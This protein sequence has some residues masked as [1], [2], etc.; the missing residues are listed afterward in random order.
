M[1]QPNRKVEVELS[2]EQREELESLC[3]RTSAPVSQVRNARVLLLADEDRRLG[4][5]PDWYIREQTGVSLRQICRIRQRFAEEGLHPAV[6]RK[7]RAAPPTP[8]RFD[9]RQE[10]HLVQLC[11]SSPPEGRKRWTLRL[12][13]DELCRLQVVA[14]VSPE[15]VRQCLKKIACSPGG[16]SGSASLKETVLGLWPTWSRCS[17]STTN[18]SMRGTL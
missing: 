13:A 18:R 9:G 16:R 3:R 7:H 14:S 12:L 1:A 8:P 6:Q 10:A 2:A 4:R 15:T 11:C 5:R 17:T